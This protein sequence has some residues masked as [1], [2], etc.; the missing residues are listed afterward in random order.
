MDHE[1]SVIDASGALRIFK[2][3][4]RS[5]HKNA[6]GLCNENASVKGMNKAANPLSSIQSGPMDH[7]HVPRSTESTRGPAP[8][9]RV[10]DARLQDMDRSGVPEANALCVSRWDIR[11]GSIMWLKARELHRPRMVCL[12]HR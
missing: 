12:G 3:H 10:A 4:G 9:S 7:P 6:S 5:T 1:E 8:R 11:S 2:D